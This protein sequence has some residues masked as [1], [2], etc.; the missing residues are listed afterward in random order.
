M[1]MLPGPYSCTLLTFSKASVGIL[2]G[3]YKSYISV[4]YLRLLIDHMEDTFC[5]CQSHDD[6]VKLLGNLHKRLCKTSGK[7][8]IRSHNSQ[9]DAADSCYGKNA[10]EDGCEHELQVSHITDDRSHHTCKSMS[11]RSAFIKALI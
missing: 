2:S 9:C 11:R 1:R 7:L 3:I 6:R 4:V 8:K 5:T 10:A